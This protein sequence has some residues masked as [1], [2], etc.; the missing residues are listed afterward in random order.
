MPNSVKLH[1]HA[2]QRFYEVHHGSNYT[3]EETAFILA[4]DRYKK[5][6]KF[7]TAC[8]YLHIAKSLGYR[9]VTDT[10]IARDVADTPTS[11]SPLPKDLAS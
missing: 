4:V 1:V 3:P 7:P 11:L 10:E 8:E 6:R 2:P 9:L 5:L